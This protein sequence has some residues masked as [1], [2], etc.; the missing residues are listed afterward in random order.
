L[1]VC[2]VLPGISLDGNSEDLYF[3]AAQKENSHLSAKGSHSML[4][5]KVPVEDLS[6]SLSQG[7]TQ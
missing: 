4:T 1:F 6:R 5:N 7:N 2:T 3:A